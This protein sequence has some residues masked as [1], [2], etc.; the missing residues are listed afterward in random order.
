M[1]LIPTRLAEWWDKTSTWVV[2]ILAMMFF[3]SVLGNFYLQFEANKSQNNHHAQTAEQQAEIKALVQKLLDDHK[4]TQQEL[5]ELA[6][7]Q[8]IADQAAA[9]LP[10][11]QN[12]LLASLGWIECALAT[13]P[14]SCG[15]RPS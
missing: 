11:G 9:T 1:T 3:F 8:K 13:S 2:A 6:S 14:S 4:T 15:T 7:I 5:S 10:A 12:K